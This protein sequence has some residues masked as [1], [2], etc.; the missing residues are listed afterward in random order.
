LSARPGEARGQ[1]RRRNCA[2]LNDER[3]ALRETSRPRL[4]V[5]VVDLDLAW[6]GIIAAVA[7]VFLHRDPR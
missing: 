4:R 7:G 1:L 3:F 2:H 6:H 5:P